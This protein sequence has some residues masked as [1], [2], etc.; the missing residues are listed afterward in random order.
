M[1]LEAAS[2]SPARAGE[3]GHVRL[4][5]LITEPSPQLTAYVHVVDGG[6]NV[7]AQSDAPLAGVYTPAERWTPGL[8]I[9]HTHEI[10]LPAALPAGVYT[11]KAGLYEPGQADAP[12]IPAG[13]GDPRVDIGQMELRHEP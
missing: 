1:V 13:Q 12:L 4:H 2:T 3:I 10:A 9:D 8:L 7:V 11:L 5:W 6:G